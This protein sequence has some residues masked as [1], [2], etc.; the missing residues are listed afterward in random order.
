M[1][2]GYPAHFPTAPP[3]AGGPAFAGPVSDRRPGGGTGKAAGCLGI[4]LAVILMLAV[5]ATVF[6]VAPVGAATLDGLL[7][8]LPIGLLTGALWLLST[9]QTLLAVLCLVAGILLI[10]RKAVGRIMLTVA[11]ATVAIGSFAEI[12]SGLSIGYFVSAVI[13]LL[14]L[15][16]AVL[17]FTLCLLPAT[18]RWLAVSPPLGSYSGYPHPFPAAPP[19]AAPG[20][21]GPYPPG[22]PH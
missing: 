19:Y 11:S 9:V 7:H 21:P 6:G 12:V 8:V 20:S 22:P 13:G 10:G 1:P 16:S 14:V 5:L 3:M 18:S 15:V 4:V 2:S 17:V